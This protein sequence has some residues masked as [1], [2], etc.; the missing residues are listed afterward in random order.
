MSLFYIQHFSAADSHV[1]EIE[2]SKQQLTALS[3]ARGSVSLTA[4]SDRRRRARQVIFEFVGIKEYLYVAG[5]SR[6][7]RG[8]YMQFCYNNN[9]DDQTD[10][11]RT[12]FTSAVV[13][14]ARLQLAFE[15]KLTVSALQADEQRCQAD[16]F[17]SPSNTRQVLHVARMHG[18]R[19]TKTMPAEA[20]LRGQWQLLQWL[21]MCGCPWDTALILHNAARGGCLQ[22]LRWLKANTRPWT[23]KTKEDMLWTACCF[24]EGRVAQWLRNEGAPWPNGFC[25]R[26]YLKDERSVALQQLSDCF[27]TTCG[28][29]RTLTCDTMVSP[30]QMLQHHKHHDLSVAVL[31]VAVVKRY[32]CCV[33]VVLVLPRGSAVIAAVLPVVLAVTL[34][35]CQNQRLH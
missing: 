33:V 26:A 2:L 13:T 9:T 17:S 14:G 34:I 4:A 27:C 24:D 16:I 1:R 18:L 11:L 35:Y 25:G 8:K 7:L 5:I 15:S 32:Y 30:L 12:S 31:L 20:A 29:N 23:D 22:T 10:K 21:R 19:W 28:C 6:H 3:Q